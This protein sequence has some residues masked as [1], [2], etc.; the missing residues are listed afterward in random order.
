[1]RIFILILAFEGLNNTRNGKGIICFKCLIIHCLALKF[2]IRYC[3][4]EYTVLPGA[5]ENSRE[6]KQW[7]RQKSNL[8]RL[9]EQELCT[10][11]TLFCTFLCRRCKTT[12]WGCLI[13][14]FVEDVNTN[15]FIFLSLDF[16]TFRIQLQKDLPTF[17]E[18]T[19]WNKRDKVWGNVNSRF[20]WRFRLD[21][22]VCVWLK[23]SASF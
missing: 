9:A 10:C 22:F 1:M 13:S 19:I 2:C 7:G 5:L 16:D 20:K 4:C 6:L 8:F 15:N 11:I 18:N 12:T 3:S 17:D 14:R 21:F 23:Q